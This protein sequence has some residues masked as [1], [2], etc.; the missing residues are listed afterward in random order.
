MHESGAQQSRDHR[1]PRSSG[2]PTSGG[3]PCED[4]TAS[5]DC[6]RTVFGLDQSELSRMQPHSEHCRTS[7]ILLPWS[8][9]KGREAEYT[10]QVNKLIQPHGLGCLQYKDGTVFTSEFVNG[11]SVVQSR[12]SHQ[13]MPLS[14]RNLRVLE[15]GDVASPQDMHI[16]LD[17][18][19]QYENVASLPDHSFAF[20]RRSTGDWTYAIVSDRPV[21]SGPN[22]SI[23]FVLN[24]RGSTKTIKAK[25]W[26]A[27]VRPVRGSVKSHDMNVDRK[28]HPKKMER[29]KSLPDNE[30][31]ARLT[32]FHRAAR[33]VS[34]DMHRMN[35]KRSGLSHSSM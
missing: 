16:E 3:L 24:S 29:R 30:E 33:R 7:V 34:L 21:K 2:R 4:S 19:R 15:L 26:S 12:S 28:E 11:T 10:G 8:D 18:Q 9:S 1:L 25:D 23:R 14:S 17:S 27:Y 22:A 32:S 13:G 20:I 6:V 5:L 35:C 31:L